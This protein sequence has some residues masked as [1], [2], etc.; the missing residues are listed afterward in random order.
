MR[1][2]TDDHDVARRHPNL[3]LQSVPNIRPR[4][5]F[6]ASEQTSVVE[7][8]KAEDVLQAFIDRYREA[9][10]DH[11]AGREAIFPAGTWWLHR[12]VGVKCAEL[13]AT[14]PPS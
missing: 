8:V 7:L 10:A 12:F 9:R 2:A 13:G 1:S 3:P 5:A 14:A 11:L 4:E 6:W